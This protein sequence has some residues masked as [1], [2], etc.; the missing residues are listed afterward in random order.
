MKKEEITKTESYDTDVVKSS[1]VYW[2]D[3][4]KYGAHN[5]KIGMN[6]V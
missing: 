3:F 2:L 1:L 6:Q 4:E 5:T